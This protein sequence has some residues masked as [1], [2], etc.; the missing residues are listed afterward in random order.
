[1]RNDTTYQQLDVLMLIV[2]SRCVCVHAGS[3]CTS[4]TCMYVKWAEWKCIH[5]YAERAWLHDVRRKASDSRILCVH[6]RETAIQIRS[7][8]EHATDVNCMNETRSITTNECT[9]KSL[10]FTNTIGPSQ[11]LL[12]ASEAPSNKYRCAREHTHMCAL[13]SVRWDSLFLTLWLFRTRFGVHQLLVLCVTVSTQFLDPF[14]D[15]QNTLDPRAQEKQK[16]KQPT[17]EYRSRVP[18]QCANELCCHFSV[19]NSWIRL[20]PYGSHRWRIANYRKFWIQC[21]RKLSKIWICQ[22]RIKQKFKETKRRKNKQTTNRR[23]SEHKWRTSF[24]PRC[25]RCGERLIRRIH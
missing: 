6:S 19:F 22:C 14:V 4:R 13:Y 15:V 9:T 10:A 2:V 20:L 7:H 23:F 1:M 24:V 21:E 25:H 12:L 11:M 8:T 5:G 18:H 3:V 17:N 16:K